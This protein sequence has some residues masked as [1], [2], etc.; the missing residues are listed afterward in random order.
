MLCFK[1]VDKRKSLA[2]CLEYREE[3]PAHT[4][5]WKIATFVGDGEP[6]LALPF[7]PGK[8]P[9][10]H[11]HFELPYIWKFANHFCV[12]VAQHE[13]KI[14][15]L[16]SIALARQVSA[17]HIHISLCGFICKYANIIL[18]VSYFLKKPFWQFAIKAVSVHIILG[19][20]LVFIEKRGCHKAIF[21]FP[22]AHTKQQRFQG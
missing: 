22:E 11:D 4:P 21:L 1:S 7:G 15:L 9:L 18:E 10:K 20:P 14:L 5:L 16:P 17:W 2:F 6:R 13:K 8:N 3:I 19:C 12:W